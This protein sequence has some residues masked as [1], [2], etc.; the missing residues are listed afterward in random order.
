MYQGKFSKNRG[1]NPAEET[2]LPEVEE[3]SEELRQLLSFEDPQ[4]EPKPEA[5]KFDPKVDEPEILVAKPAPKKKAKKET[6][7]EPAPKK[8]DK[9]KKKKKKSKK[10]KGNKYITTIFYTLWF[11]L[12][13]GFFGAMHFALGFVED[14]LV[15]Y[16]ASQPTTISQAVFEKHF[17]N[18]DWADI[19]DRAG[20]E[21][22]QFEDKDDF[23][24]YMEEKYADVTFTYMET[25]A[26]LSGGHKYNLKNGDETIGYFTLT[27]KNAKDPSDAPAQ[28]P[29]DLAEELTQLPDW[30]L[31]KVSVSF[32]RN[33]S[34]TIQKIDGHT[35]Y[36]NGV[37]V[38]DD[39]TTQIASTV[40]EEYLPAGT[41]GFR[42]IRQTIS[43]LLLEPEV[44]I[45]DENGNPSTVVYDE[46][47]GIY[48]E[49][50]EATTISLE[51]KETVIKAAEDYGLFMIE[52]AGS[53][54]LS[55]TWKSTSDSYKNITK[56]ERWFSGC[57]DYEFVNHEVSDYVRY[58]DT[59]FSARVKYSLNVT[60]KDDTIKEFK[61]DTTLFFEKQKSGKW[62]CIEMTNRDVQEQ[63]AEV[64][65]TFLDASGNVIST[66]F[67]KDNA[68]ELY[69]PVLTVPAG[70]VLDGWYVETV[71]ASGAKTLT[72]AFRSDESGYI[73]IPDGTELIPMVLQPVFEDADLTDPTESEVG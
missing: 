28:T 68:P 55:K 16:E 47:T 9:K 57:K 71:D 51:E 52:K 22:T 6:V 40:A 29:G 32:T 73:E 50:T 69:A 37:A 44:T 21:S 72:L 53:G 43:G 56:L 36:V 62:M 39:F 46:N 63:I 14:W 49:F 12:I 42:L 30:V 33:E 58:N 4:P 64:R 5:P 17:Q 45:L 66:E 3:M 38:G 18:P 70:K 25:S 60:R 54:N 2:T 65:I 67:V 10:K 8:A 19:Y 61:L 35:A 23:V 7:E 31:D 1:Q 11:L 26:G 41:T 59:L 34:V 20:I 48:T 15:K 27:D 13:I 24:A